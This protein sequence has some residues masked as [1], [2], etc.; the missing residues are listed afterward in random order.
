[1]QTAIAERDRFLTERL[2]YP[3]G[4]AA[5]Y[6]YKT[7]ILLYRLG[8]G[9]LVGRLFMIMTTTGRKSGLPRRTAIEYHAYGG[10]KYVLVGWTQSDWYKNIMANPLL[11]IQTA[12][13][14]ERVR[15]RRLD[16]EAER[17]EAWKV[18]EHSPIIQLA[19]K[20]EKVPLTED[21]FAAEKD[22]FI[23]L[24]FDPTDEPTPPPLEAD[25][26]W[27]PSVILNIAGTYFIQ[28]AIRRWVRRRQA[29]RPG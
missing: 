11:T 8:L 17:R 18:A 12:D 10:R 23:I 3:S 13:G 1:M 25:L 5:K 4:R 2:P 22:R 24:T 26:K 28:R 14:V 9:P 19:M 16:G 21:Q 7:P 20:L 27:V 15:A 29:K 6:L